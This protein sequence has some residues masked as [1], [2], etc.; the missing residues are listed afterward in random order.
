MIKESEPEEI[1]I[2]TEPASVHFSNYDNV[3]D[4]T[5]DQASSFKYVPKDLEPGEI[6][7]LEI[8]EDTSSPLSLDSSV[9]ELEAPGVAAPTSGLLVDEILE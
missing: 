9:T 3:F 1:T 6:P 7:R 4:E 5:N 8:K 2:D